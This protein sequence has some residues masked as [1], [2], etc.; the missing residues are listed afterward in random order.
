MILSTTNEKLLIANQVQKRLITNE[1]IRDPNNPNFKYIKEKF[2][3]NEPNDKVALLNTGSCLFQSVVDTYSFYVGTK[4]DKINYRRF[5]EDFSVFWYFTYSLEREENWEYTIVYQPAENYILNNGID[6]VYRRYQDSNGTTLKEYILE[7]TFVGGVVE[8]KLRDV[9]YWKSA[10]M[11]VNGVQVPLDTIRETKELQEYVNTWLENVFRV[12]KEDA[13]EQFPMSPIKKIENIVYSIDRKIVMMDTQFLQHGE[14]FRIFKGIQVPTKLLD[15]YTEWKAIDFSVLGHNIIWNEN[16]SIEYV[17][18]KNEL[19]DKI[20]IQNENQ[21]RNISAITSVPVDFLW[22]ES[23]EW[24]VGQGSRTLLQWSFLKK[25]EW[26]R[27]F[28]DKSF[29]EVNDIVGEDDRTWSDIFVKNDNELINELKVARETKLISQL[30]AI[31]EYLWV[32]KDEAQKEIELIN[33]EAQE[34]LSLMQTNAN[35]MGSQQDQEDNNGESVQG[36]WWWETT[37]LRNS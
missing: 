27:S 10:S 28:L 14:V 35:T 22:L 34:T 21:I 36:D 24:N 2:F 16:S 23:K 3:Y 8:N 19:I 20:M 9:T 31:Q 33:G 1:Y 25:I 26:F 18:N 13:R 6:T 37:D 12:C 11:W 4:N 15:A 17:Q 5:I 32:D 29:E 7:T 30:R